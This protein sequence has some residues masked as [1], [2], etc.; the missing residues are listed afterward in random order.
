MDNVT[1]AYIAGFLDGDGSIML[2]IKPRTTCRYKY[3]ITSTICMYQRKNQEK[4]LKW[5]RN[6]LKLG[7][8]SRR[9]DG[10]SEYRIDG[11]KRVI[12][13]LN[14]LEP[15]LVFKKAQVKHI[16]RTAKLLQKRNLTPKKFFLLCK[17]SDR[18]ASFNYS[19]SRKNT[20]ETVRR[21]F[22]K[23]KLLSP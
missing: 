13:V 22:Q 18:V 16:L 2:Q 14:M 9:N 3:R 4:G 15:Y 17:L 6:Q 1:K 8:M 20:S 11:H 5:I 7:Y 21:D 10:M 23:R 19:V 12:E